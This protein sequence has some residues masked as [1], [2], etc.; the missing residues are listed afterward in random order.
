MKSVMHINEYNTEVYVINQNGVCKT[1]FMY[2]YINKG[3]TVLHSYIFVTCKNFVNQAHILTAK[4]FL[5]NKSYHRGTNTG[6]FFQGTKK[7]T[8]F[9]CLL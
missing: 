6:C 8:Y 7:S 9:H 3:K 1:V 5:N 4:Y 2:I